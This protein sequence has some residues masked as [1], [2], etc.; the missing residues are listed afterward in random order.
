MSL[1]QEESLKFWLPNLKETRNGL[2]KLETEYSLSGDQRIIEAV[3]LLQ[4]FEEAIIKDWIDF[5]L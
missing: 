5:T 3:G 4:L 2:I 1:L